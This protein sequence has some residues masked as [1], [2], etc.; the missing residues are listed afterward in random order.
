MTATH[1]DQ[2]LDILGKA[3]DAVLAALTSLDDWGL[4]HTRPGQYR[5]DL[6]A[7]EAALT[8]LHDAGMAVLSEESGRTG[9]GEILVVLDPVDGSTNASHGIPWWATS[10][11]AFDGDGPC[12]ALVVNQALGIRYE[13]VR[14]GGARRDG[15]AI[16]PSDCTNLNRAIVG[17]GD[18]PERHLGWAQFRAL[19]ASALELCAVAEGAL[20]AFCV[21]PGGRI[22]GWDYLGA[23]LVCRE[24]GAT[25]AEGD[26]RELLVTDGS[27]RRP[28]ATA[29][30]TLMGHLMTA[31][32]GRRP[33]GLGLRSP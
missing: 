29:T 10:L 16:R 3:A 33:D 25:L 13:A 9:D 21:P 5:H 26:G 24:A 17:L 12:A 19:G 7:D 1:H 18:Y 32:D 4:A 31:M 23:F 30:A 22:F 20:D 28:V 6:V 27:A 15:Q 14:G 11:C 8:V 2:V